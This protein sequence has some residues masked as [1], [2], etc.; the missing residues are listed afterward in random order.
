MAPYCWRIYTLLWWGDR[1]GFTDASGPVRV[2]FQGFGDADI[3][4]YNLYK[5][6]IYSNMR[7]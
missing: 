7:F 3:C 2:W 6:Q 5:H 1:R 4:R